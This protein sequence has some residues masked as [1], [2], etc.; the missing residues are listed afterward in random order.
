RNDGWQR[1]RG[2]N[3]TPCLMEKSRAIMSPYAAWGKTARGENRFF[4][5]RIYSLVFYLFD[6]YC[7]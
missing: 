6:Y 2:H 5:Q 4:K 3:N 1:T 7:E